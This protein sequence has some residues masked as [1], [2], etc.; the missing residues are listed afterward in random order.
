MADALPKFEAPPVVE[1]LLAVQ[2]APLPEFTGA[3]SG[4]FWKSYL[5]SD[6][7]KILATIRF[8]CRINLNALEA[9]PG[10]RHPVF[11]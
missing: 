1:T 3:M 4:W 10:G 11:S 9:M 8:P 5:G 2:F 7:T 6:W